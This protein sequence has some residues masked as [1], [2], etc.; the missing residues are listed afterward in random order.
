MRFLCEPFDY[1]ESAVTKK[2]AAN[3]SRR[4]AAI[5]RKATQAP[6]HEDK[7]NVEEVDNSLANGTPVPKKVEAAAAASNSNTSKWKKNKKKAKKWKQ[8][9]PTA[10]II[11]DLHSTFHLATC[12]PISV[13]TC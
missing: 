6:S 12:S 8:I 9:T 11:I 3:S 5:H 1:V 7:W 13:V 4:T 2:D 10:G